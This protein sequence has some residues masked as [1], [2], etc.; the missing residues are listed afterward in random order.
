MRSARDMQK[1]QLSFTSGSLF[2]QGAPIAAKL[3]AETGDW[4]LVRARLR[5]ENL[6]QA[7][8][9]ST[10]SRLA[11]EVVQRLGNLTS[12]ELALLADATS[13]ELRQLMWIATCRQYSLIGEFA[14]EVLRDRYLLLKYELLPSHFDSFVNGKKL[15]HEELSTVAESTLKRLRSNLF[16]M[17]RE[18]ELVTDKGTIV[19]TVISARILKLLPNRTPNDVRFFPTSEAT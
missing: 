12:E 5:S 17:L 2:L 6:L 10:A 7:R 1:Y 16:A 9:D 3:Y 11:F 19:P 18:A 8:T 14:E 15:W 13:N 4:A